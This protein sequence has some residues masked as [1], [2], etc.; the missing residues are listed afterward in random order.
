MLDIDCMM[1][2]KCFGQEKNIKKV[3]ETAI[4][5]ISLN[6]EI[7]SF[8]DLRCKNLK[9]DSFSFKTSGFEHISCL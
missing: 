5:D 2:D 8:S 3:N 1:I 4:Y 6:R 7:A 9:Q